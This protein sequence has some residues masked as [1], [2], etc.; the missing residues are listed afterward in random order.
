MHSLSKYGVNAGS[1]KEGVKTVDQA[2]SFF[3]KY[4]IIK[5]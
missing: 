3:F 2:I 4:V 5:T 1:Q